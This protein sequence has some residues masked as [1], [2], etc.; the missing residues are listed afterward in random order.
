M[1]RCSAPGAGGVAAGL[2]LEGRGGVALGERRQHDLAVGELGFGVVL[3]L[4]VG[5]QEPGEVDD[6]ALASKVASVPASEPDGTGAIRRAWALTPV[7]SAIWE[8]TVRFQISS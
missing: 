5:P 1:P 6:P 4:H 2:E 7:A 3:A 8:A